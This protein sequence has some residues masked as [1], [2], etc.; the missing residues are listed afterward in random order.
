MSLWASVTIYIVWSIY[1]TIIVASGLYLLHF[2]D[3]LKGNVHKSNE[4]GTVIL[5]VAINSS[6]N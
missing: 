2:S 1:I 5:I 4:R 6:F 3:F